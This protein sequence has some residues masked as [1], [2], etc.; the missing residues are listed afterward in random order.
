MAA[1]GGEMAKP[2]VVI[3]GGCGFIGRNL[4]QYLIENDL[5]SA[6]RVVD[7]VPPQTAWLNDK[8][9]Q[10]FNIPKVQFKSANLIN[11]ASC[12]YALSVEE[13]G[14]DYVINCACET[15]VG[16]T[17]PVYREGILKLSLNC[18]AEAAKLNVKRFVEVS[19][20]HMCSS[21]KVPHKEDGKVEPWTYIAKFKRQVEEEL[22][23]IPGLRFTVVRPAIV[24]GIGDRHGLAPR[25]VI[26]AV[27][28]H[29]GEMMKLLWGKDLKMNTIHVTDLCRA[30]W[31]LAIRD[32]TL[33]QIYN[34]V[35]KGDTTQGMI[36][37]LVSEIFN[38]NH[39]YWGSV[40]LSLCKL[41]MASLVDEVND[42]H[43]GPWAE[44]C[45][46][47]GVENTPLTPYI[48]QE[49]LYNKHLYLDPSKLESTGFSW[50]VPQITRNK[51]QEI[52]DDYAEMNLFPRSLIL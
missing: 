39:D 8:H 33:S 42:K 6:V 30:I 9:Q 17:D 51:L 19:T 36:S 10:L 38:I 37:N 48:D 31:H 46:Q 13:G 20:G 35:D 34:V 52:I 26:G 16:Q 3:L 27:Y 49:L 14:W 23:N 40:S 21:N 43:L 1:D 4:V 29:L 32:D 50:L 7:K 45:N 22:H 2:S 47:S 28:K 44:A 5:V 41:D 18:A 12:Q 11:P 24:Y 15:K 25:L